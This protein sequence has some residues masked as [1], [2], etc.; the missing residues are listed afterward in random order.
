MGK[1]RVD[2][3]FTDCLR[4]G[5]I[6]PFPRGRELMQK[7]LD[8]ADSDLDE[9]KRSFENKRYKWSTI[10]S[11]YA[12]FHTARALLYLEGYRERS[13]HCLIVALRTLY[14]SKKL[15][16]SLFI[17]ALQLGKRL[18]EDADYYGEF[19]ADGAN[20]MLTSA[21]EFLNETKKIIK[22]KIG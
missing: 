4:K 22:I 5:K 7:E 14:V 8:F 3:E 11:Y 20:K 16:S 2:S 18:R 21:I 15:L 19:S 1:E 13:H 12:M 17:E 10:Q 6:R 9:A